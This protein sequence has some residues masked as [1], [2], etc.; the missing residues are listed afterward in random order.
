ML[1]PLDVP[2]CSEDRS[3]H[4]FDQGDELPDRHEHVDDLL[5]G[6]GVDGQ[7]GLFALHL[8]I[9]PVKMFDT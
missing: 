4:R 2:I 7:P 9:P 5:D 6:L 1:A 8:K 3:G